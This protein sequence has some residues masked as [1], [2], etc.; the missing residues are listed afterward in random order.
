MTFKVYRTFCLIS[1]LFYSCS[2]DHDLLPY[3]STQLDPAIDFKGIH[4]TT[5]G[6]LYV[7]GGNPSLG[8]IFESN[9]NGLSWIDKQTYFD[10]WINDIWVNDQNE[11]LCIDQDVLIYRSVDEGSSWNQYFPEEWPLSVTRNLRDLIQVDSSK[12]LICGGKNFSNGLIYFSENNGVDWD[13]EEF[14]HELR[15]IYFNDPT[16]GVA[17]G[18]GTVL[19]TSDGGSSWRIIDTYNEYYTGVTGDFGQRYWS[20]GFNGGIYFS[21]NNGINWDRIKSSN[22]TFSARDRFTCIQ[23]HPSGKIVCCGVDGL[24]AISSD[25][26]SNWS[27]YESFMGKTINDFVIINSKKAV[28]VADD[29]YIFTVNI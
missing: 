19:H 26:G 2:K 1:I 5:S 6:K 12:Y 4:L 11:G 24:I 16:N 18:Y 23:R 13:F 20:C 8:V 15:S 25:N 7:S 9:D 27:F 21:N 10:K 22:K 28:A 3:S 14:N 29:G 17:V